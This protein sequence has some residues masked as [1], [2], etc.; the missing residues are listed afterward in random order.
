MWTS[1]ICTLSLHDAL[2]ICVGSI[3]I[4]EREGFTAVG[5]TVAVGVFIA[6]LNAVAVGVALGRIQAVEDPDGDR[7]RSEEHTSEL[8]SPMYLVFRLLLEKKKKAEAQGN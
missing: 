8:Q 5:Q 2:P 3:G 4:G 1:K 7:L 6:V